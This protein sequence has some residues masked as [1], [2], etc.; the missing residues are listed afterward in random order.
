MDSKRS[1]LSVFLVLFLTSCSFNAGPSKNES[2]D[3]EIEKRTQEMYDDIDEAFSP[4][5]ES[6]N[7]FDPVDL[8]ENGLISA[9]DLFK[10]YEHHEAWADKTFNGN[11]VIVR[12]PVY[13]IDA[14]KDKVYVALTAGPDFREVFCYFKNDNEKDLLTLKKNLMKL[15]KGDEVKIKGVGD[16]G[17]K[18]VVVLKDCVLV[19]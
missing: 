16:G 3:E 7:I 15:K 5:G 4:V 1:V 12:G 11:T 6:K 17:S 10:N 19:K 13:E 2:S 8:D 9:S 18:E 14:F